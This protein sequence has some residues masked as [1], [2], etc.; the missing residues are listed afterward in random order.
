MLGT[1]QVNSTTSLSHTT[2]CIACNQSTET[3][4]EPNPGADPAALCAGAVDSQGV[5][6]TSQ[7]GKR[8]AREGGAGG[9]RGKRPAKIPDDALMSQMGCSQQV[10]CLLLSHL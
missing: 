2:L 9:A 4:P 7:R 10:I 6:N 3:K 1:P 8:K 5:S